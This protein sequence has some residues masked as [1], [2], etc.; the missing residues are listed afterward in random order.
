VYIVKIIGPNE[1]CERV[2]EN[3]LYTIHNC[4]LPRIQRLVKEI[5]R[6]DSIHTC[7]KC[8]SSISYDNWSPAFQMRHMFDEIAQNNILKRRV[9]MEIGLEDL[10]KKYQR[11]P[12][13]LMQLII[14]Y[15]QI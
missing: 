4:H 13:D 7:L 15:I 5:Q 12:Q 6:E 11:L 9:S 2:E 3:Y 1:M 10:F 14:S 8:R